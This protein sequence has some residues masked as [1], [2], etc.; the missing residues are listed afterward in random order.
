MTAAVAI[1]ASTPFPKLDEVVSKV[2]A[3]SKEFAKLS[4]DERVAMLEAFRDGYR[5]A[6]H[7]GEVYLQPG[8]TPDN[9]KEHQA[10]FYRKPHDGRL[11]LVL[12]AGNVNAIAPTDVVYKMFVEGTACILKMNP[13]NA[14][15]GPFIE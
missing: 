3:G 8:I 1:P 7:V 5:L 13:V 6:K 2:K 12:G 14:Y 11:C 10:A 4:I 15:L 9:V